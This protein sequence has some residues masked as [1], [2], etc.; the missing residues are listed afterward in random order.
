MCDI[1][2]MNGSN[3]VNNSVYCF[4]VYMY[5]YAYNVLLTNTCRCM[6]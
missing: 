2:F 6:K 3:F 5:N 1:M 4:N